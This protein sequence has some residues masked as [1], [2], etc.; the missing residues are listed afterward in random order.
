MND[1]RFERDLRAVLARDVPDTVPLNLRASLQRVVAG[2]GDR[3]ADHPGFR[4]RVSPF[5]A[6]LASFALVGLVL[7]I[8]VSW[9]GGGPNFGGAPDDAS[10][11]PTLQEPETCRPARIPDP[12]DVG[13]VTE[14]EPGVVHGTDLSKMTSAEAAEW[15]AERKL[16]ATWRFTY[17]THAD[18]P[19]RMYTEI[20]CTPPDGEVHGAYIGNS[21]GIVTVFV[22]PVENPVLR[23]RPQPKLGWGCG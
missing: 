21:D 6:G 8:V 22:R 9:T 23:M 11:T 5:L 10:P 17:R 3:R 20:W 14:P 12:S 2:T 16:C 7:S 13:G 1:E 19:T 4:P 18:D 15:L